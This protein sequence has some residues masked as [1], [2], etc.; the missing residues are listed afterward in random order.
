[1]AIKSNFTRLASIPRVTS[2]KSS[3]VTNSFSG[4][5]KT[6]APND[7]VKLNELELAQDARMERIGHYKTRHGADLFT[8][9]IGVVEAINQFG[10]DDQLLDIGSSVSLREKVTPV[11]D[12]R[13]WR[14]D[15]RATRPTGTSGIIKIDIFDDKNGIPSRR[16]ATTTLNPT[17]LTGTVSTVAAVFIEA[18]DLKSGEDYW[19]VVSTQRS[20]RGHLQVSASDGGE[21]W[22]SAPDGRELWNQIDY[23]L[24]FVLY[25]AAPSGVSN[26]FVYNTAAIQATLFVTGGALYR[27][28]VNGTVTLIR[29]LPAGVQKVRFSQ[30][31]GQ[32]RYTTGLEKPHLIDPANGWTD[33]EIGASIANASNLM[34]RAD[35]L[36]YMNPD[37]PTQVFWTEE[38]SEDHGYDTFNTD[39]FQH[40]PS[41]NTGDNITAFFDLGGVMYVST[42]RR[43]YSMFTQQV[44]VWNMTP[45]TCQKGTFSQ[46]S[47]TFDGTVAYF[48][49]DEGIYAFDGTSVVDL[50]GTERNPRIQNVYGAIRNKESIVLDQYSNHLYVFY[51]SQPTGINDSCL[52]YNL[53]TN[54]WESFDTDTFASA[55]CARKNPRMQFLQGHSRVGALMIGESLANGY[56]NLGAP[57]HYQLDEP[58]RPYGTPSERKRISKWRP[59][60]KLE[61]G[62]YA[63]E[64]GYSF[65]FS[66][67]I[68]YAFSI[69]LSTGGIRWDEG[70][71]WDSGQL[72]GGNSD[73]T[74]MTTRTG[75][76]GEW[77]RCSLHY[78]HHAAYEPVEFIAHTVT[79]QTQRIR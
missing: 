66:G 77:R 17:D 8:D 52:V 73:G 61:P 46:E 29:Q 20:G 27:A 44:D 26:I 23:S 59:E 12:I 30:D 13:L 33:T 10:N 53:N 60:F 47:L 41:P 32:I 58:Q 15:L 11:D 70:Y 75:V 16:L 36:Y 2:R 21:L 57:I 51:S 42:R 56:S 39:Y 74:R 64:C 35:S 72:W 4:G 18:P 54:M 62:N 25:S 34:N 55:T 43:M 68:R 28:D 5:I 45:S 49:G 3:P 48:A 78:R 38:Y 19:V 71:L 76:Y 37:E 40:F 63:V 24:N 9:P 31:L 6:Y 65:D 14:I 50:T 22:Q 69:D 79:L 67:E 7:D 1:M